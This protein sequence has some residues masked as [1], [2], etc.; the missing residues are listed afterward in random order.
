MNTLEQG[1]YAEKIFELKCIEK[2]WE[3][4]EPITSQTRCDYILNRG[5][6]FERC[7][8]KGTTIKNG[9]LIISLFKRQTNSSDKKVYFYTKDEIDTFI[10]VDRDNKDNVYLIP[11]IFE[12]GRFQVSLRLEPTKNKQ[13]KKVTYASDYLA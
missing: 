6:G 1:S 7:Q 5:N 4:F 3:C 12:K 9:K 2:G 13:T 11:N 8:V 10:A